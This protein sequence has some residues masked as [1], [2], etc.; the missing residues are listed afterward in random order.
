[1]SPVVMVLIAFGVLILIA[2]A[3]TAVGLANVLT[4][5]S[6]MQERIQAYA[7]IPEAGPR[8]ELGRRNTGLAR[9]RLRLNMAL[10]SLGSEDMNLQLM[11]ANWSITVTEYVVIR[12]GVT[13]ASFLLGWLLTRWVISGIG[14]A[15][16]AYLLPGILLQ[17]SVH[18]RRNQFNAQLV[19]VLTLIEGAVKAGFSLLQA[20]EVVEKEMHAPASEEFRRLQ[21]EVGLG[22]SLADALTNLAARMENRDLDLV[23]TA[24]KIHYQVG[25]NLARMLSAVTETIRDRIRLFSEVRVITT[26]QRYTSYLLSVLPILLGAVLFIVNPRYMSGL[27]DPSIRCVPI[28]ALLG[29]VIGHFAIRRI[30]K[31]E[32]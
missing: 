15:I 5:D 9:L 19:D 31:L 18:Q 24:I 28:A 13:V 12:F 11:S 22:L 29:I 14:L 1:M 4:S 20:V 8:R 27:W 26:Q 17:R 16:I 2:A 3:L 23:V 25:G 21:R 10:S 30:T 32:V 7:A 6:G